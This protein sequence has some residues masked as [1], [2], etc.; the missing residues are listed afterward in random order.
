MENVSIR[1]ADPRTAGTVDLAVWREKASA[2]LL[3]Y[4]GY[5]PESEWYHVAGKPVAGT[6][7]VERI[8]IMTSEASG[9][10]GLAESGAQASFAKNDKVFVIASG[11][12]YAGQTSV[13]PGSTERVSGAIIGSGRSQGLLTGVAATYRIGRDQNVQIEVLRRGMQRGQDGEPVM[14]DGVEALDGTGNLG[15]GGWKWR[16]FEAKWDDGALVPQD[17]N[18]LR[19]VELGGH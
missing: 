13:I 5:T 17:H 1:A 6:E 3:A 12:P 16:N 15:G 7:L 14:K 19:R 9:H 10:Y 18:E 8:V 2:N 4:Q 11:G